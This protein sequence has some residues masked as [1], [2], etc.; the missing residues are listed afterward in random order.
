MVFRQF[1]SFRTAILKYWLVDGMGDTVLAA[2]NEV[3]KSDA[4][5]AAIEARKA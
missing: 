1:S 3:E 4:D 2:P 5:Q